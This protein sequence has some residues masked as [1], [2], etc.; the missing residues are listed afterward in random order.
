LNPEGAPL[1]YHLRLLEVYRDTVER[2][3]LAPPPGY[4]QAG[5]GRA[6]FSVSPFMDV[7]G[8]NDEDKVQTSVTAS[9]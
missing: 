5:P 3:H 1:E 4:G 9:P 7:L 8:M 2:H 6:V